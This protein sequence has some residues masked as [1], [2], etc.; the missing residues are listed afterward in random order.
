MS[1]SAEEW[2]EQAE[3]LHQCIV[4]CGYMGRVADG[5]CVIV[6]VRK[7][8]VPVA[9]AEILKGNRIGQFYAD[10]HDRDDCLPSEEVRTA[11]EKWLNSL[12]KERAA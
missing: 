11:L 2:R 5:K 10:E 1:D 12:G 3:A 9:T 4:S 7:G 8:G 6:F